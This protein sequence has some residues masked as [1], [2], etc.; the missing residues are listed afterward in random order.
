MV[1]AKLTKVLGDERA[2]RY[3]G[4]EFCV[5]FSGPSVQDAIPRLEILRREVESSSFTLRDPDRPA[6]KPDT[7]RS[8]DAPSQSVTVSIGVAEA[9]DRNTD[10]QTVIKAADEALYRAKNAGRNTISV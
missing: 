9:K 6:K 2:F 7:P 5:L 8:N 4:E 3:G 10:P 1:A